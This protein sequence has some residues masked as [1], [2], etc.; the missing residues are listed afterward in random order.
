MNTVH[1]DF[2]FTHGI[3]DLL[4]G[5]RVENMDDPSAVTKPVINGHCPTDGVVRMNGA[6]QADALG[7]AS[8]ILT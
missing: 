8:E 4:E 7:P 1:N 5:L 3:F 6:H 2:H